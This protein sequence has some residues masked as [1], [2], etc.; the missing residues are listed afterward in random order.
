MDIKGKSK[1][2]RSPGSKPVSIYL[3]P[4]TECGRVPAFSLR[5][6]LEDY[7][8]EELH[9]H[10]VHQLLTI[11]NGVSLL[12]D[13]E[14]TR[15][16][17]RNMA[18]FIPAGHAHRS[19]VI[20]GPVSYQSVYIQKRSYRNAPEDLCI[21]TLSDLSFTLM[22]RLC[23]VSLQN[24]KEGIN[25][26]CLKLFTRTVREDITR[27]TFQI[28]LPEAGTGFCKIITTFVRDHYGNQIRLSQLRSLIP[29]SSRHVSRLF[30]QDM[31]MSIFHYIRL[32][33]MVMASISL[34]TGT[35]RI[36]DI[37]YDCGYESLSSFFC[38]FRKYY[39]ISPGE[40]RK[41]GIQR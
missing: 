3:D 39:G 25:G 36:I 40:F 20:G 24:L 17:Y 22:N 11:F 34:R 7:S 35:D 10:E 31:R 32:Y 26:D 6:E 2:G 1:T 37:A 30:R 4:G 41:Q 28:L 14:G 8:T 38:D 12:V 29:L 13:P 21:F 15:P 18:A 19:T 27:G 23:Q 5:G 16:L 33:R 9:Y